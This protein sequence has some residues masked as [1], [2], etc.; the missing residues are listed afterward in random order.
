MTFR[1]AEKDDEQNEYDG[2]DSEVL[3]PKTAIANVELEQE[4]YR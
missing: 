1:E 3:T 4:C 2:R